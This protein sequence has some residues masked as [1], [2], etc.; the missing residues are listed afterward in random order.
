MYTADTKDTNTTTMNPTEERSMP[1]SYPGCTFETGLM[2]EKMI[3]VSMNNHTTAHSNPPKQQDVDAYQSSKSEKVKRPSISMG[4]ILEDYAYFSSRWTRF[5]KLS[6]IPKAD[7]ASQLLECCDESLQRDLFRVH[8]CFE[9]KDEAFVMSMI[10]QHAV[11][12]ENVVLAIVT[13]L[14]MRQDRDEPIRNYAA[15]LKGQAN[16]CKYTIKNKC[17]ICD[18][19]SY[20]NYSE[21]MVRHVLASGLADNEIQIDLLGNADQEMPLDQIINFIEAKE[22]GKKSASCLSETHKNSA[23]R[24]TYKHN[25]NQAIRSYNQNLR[26][27]N[28]QRTR[29]NNQNYRGENIQTARSNSQHFRVENRKT[30][31]NTTHCE[32]CGRHGHGNYRDNE[33]RKKVCPA[34][35]KRCKNCNMWNHYEKMCRNKTSTGQSSISAIDED[36][37]SDSN[38]QVGAIRE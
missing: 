1:C 26:G 19:E 32:W 13:H 5:K 38:D 22:V 20:I 31:S 7:I 28:T 12:R 4:C 8:D 15:R 10:K 16:S 25:A 27:E 35:N 9:D 18:H 3:E 24:S 34:F 30:K 11:N 17:S 2:S 14:Q 29:S 33:I 23:V 36:S 37:F 21:E 6:K